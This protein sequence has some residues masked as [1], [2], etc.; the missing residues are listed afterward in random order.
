M[1]TEPSPPLK[2]LKFS[3]NEDEIE[4]RISVLSKSRSDLPYAR[5]KSSLE[6]ELT[7]FLAQLNF[8]KDIP[9]CRPPE[10]IKFLVGKD[11]TGRTKS[12]Q[13]VFAKA[14]KM[15]AKYNS[16]LLLRILGCLPGLP[17]IEGERSIQQ[18]TFRYDSF[19]WTN[20]NAYHVTSH[21]QS[22]TDI[23]ETKLP[24]YWTLPFSKKALSGNEDQSCST[25]TQLDSFELSILRTYP[26]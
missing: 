8:P 4:Q 3:V 9:S 21:G 17:R 24:T 1:M 14:L 7:A 23:Q 2:K 11:K 15:L 5:Q 25:T 13:R 22:G 26:G 16:S 12:K 10:I 19:L 20:R 6:A 18:P